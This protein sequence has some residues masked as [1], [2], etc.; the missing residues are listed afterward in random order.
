[1]TSLLSVVIPTH[2][3][4]QDV[5]RAARSVLAQDVAALEVVVVDDAS[6][7]DTAAVLE[8]L[9]QDDRRVRVLHTEDGPLGPCRSRNHGLKA[10]QGELVAFCDDDDAWTPEASSR[11]LARLEQDHSLGAVS[12]WHRVEHLG[13]GRS[14][15]YRGPLRYDHRQ[16]LWQNFVGVPFGIIRRGALSFEVSF[17]PALPT[18][19]DWDL[20][21]RCARERPME[22]VPHVCYVYSQ[23]SGHRVTAGLGSQITGRRNFLSKHEAEMV[24]SCRLFHEAVLAGYAG[25]RRAMTETLAGGARHHPGQAAAAGTLLA[26]SALASWAGVRRGDPGLQGRV[27]ASLVKRLPPTRP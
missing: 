18:G 12:G 26:T 27:M 2:N 22:T 6:T 1:M 23:H 17:D 24:P 20:W 9:A 14:A 13:T 5:A 11:A 3:R 8:R 7:D 25:G 21:L 16:L 15:V 10:A 4:A 19:E